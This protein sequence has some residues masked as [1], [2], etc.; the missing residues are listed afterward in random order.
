MPAK[1]PCVLHFV[2][3]LRK[4]REG[5]GHA[6]TSC[7]RFTEDRLHRYRKSRC[8]PLEWRMGCVFKDANC[9]EPC[10]LLSGR[11]S[12]GM[13]TKWTSLRRRPYN[14]RAPLPLRGPLFVMGSLEERKWKK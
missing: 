1:D 4:A 13:G 11:A 14:L 5:G 2:Q 9:F 10:H 3:R 6:R 7:L 8:A 12:S